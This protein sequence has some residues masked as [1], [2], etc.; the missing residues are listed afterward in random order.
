VASTTG[1]VATFGIALAGLAAMNASPSQATTAIA[2]SLF[3][4]GLLSIF[5]SWR[6]RMPISVVWSTP[7][8]AFLATSGAIGV[9]FEQAVGGFLLSAVLLTLTGLW[10]ALGR[11]VAKIPP[12]ISAAM[13]A[14]VIFPFVLAVVH[15]SIE[16]PALLVPVLLVWVLLMKWLKL[17]A[18]PVAILLGFVLI[19]TSPISQ[20]RPELG[21]WPDFAIVVPDCGGWSAVAIGVPLYLITMASQNLPG[22]AIMSSLG[23]PL[24]A[25]RVLMTTGSGSILASFFGSFGLNLAAITAALNADE[26][27][28]KD[29]SRRWI[30]ASFGGLVYIVFGIFAAGFA[31]FVLAVPRELLLSLAGLALMNTFAGSLKT[32]MTDEQTR[33]PAATTFIIGAAGVT[34]YSIGGAFWALLVGLAVWL[35]LRPSRDVA[36]GA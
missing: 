20:Q 11:L 29:P 7:G 34:L 25:S 32:A 24:S 8:A 3:G 5:L 10:P 13:L 19:A 26:H 27:A 4:Y 36:S 17:W 35:L 22:L 18:S 21:F 31:S 12:A 15:S 2:V 30:A 6:T 1:S 23:Y 33:L 9:S 16:Y 28:A 14:G